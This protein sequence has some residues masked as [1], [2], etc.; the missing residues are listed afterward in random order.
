MILN[1]IRAPNRKTTYE[2]RKNERD[3]PCV[4]D[5]NVDNDIYRF[6][7]KRYENTGQNFFFRAAQLPFSLLTAQRKGAALRRI[8]A[9]T[10]DLER[11]NTG[12]IMVWRTKFIPLVMGTP[13]SYGV[14][15]KK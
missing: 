8:C 9:T 12:R 13:L 5:Q 14:N 2:Q 4:H 6:L 1:K 10:Q 11:W 7:L 15:I 3:Y